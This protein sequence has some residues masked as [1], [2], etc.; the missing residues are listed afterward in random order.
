MNEADRPVFAARAATTASLAHRRAGTARRDTGAC[1]SRRARRT[2]RSRPSRCSR[3]RP[4]GCRRKEIVPFQIAC[5]GSLAGAG[6]MPVTPRPRQKVLLQTKLHAVSALSCCAE[7]PRRACLIFSA[8]TV[9]RTEPSMNVRVVVAD[10][11][12]ATFFDLD[13]GAMRRPKRA[14]R[15]TTTQRARIASSRPTGPAVAS[16]ALT[17]TG[18][19]ST[20][21]AAPSGTKWSCS[22]RKSPARWT[23]RARGT[24]SIDSSSSPGR[25]CSACCAKHC[26]RHA[27]RSSRRKSPKTLARPGSDSIRDAVPRDAFLMNI[28]PILYGDSAM[29][30]ERRFDPALRARTSRRTLSRGADATAIKPGA[31]NALTADREPAG[32][33]R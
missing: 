15:C 2:L 18:T 33:R 8:I 16:A 27:A 7:H 10:E 4:C 32:E 1:A 31:S 28:P 12:E 5:H 23:V 11:R 26:R 21:S 17:A 22:P 29:P 3:V 20:A 13:E 6:S 25:A 30:N 14:A 19:R 24:S 9:G